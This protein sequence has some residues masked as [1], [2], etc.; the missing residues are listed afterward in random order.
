MEKDIYERCSRY[1]R[2]Y[3][4]V[5]FETTNVIRTCGSTLPLDIK[6]IN[7]HE[8][9]LICGEIQSVAQEIS[10]K[11]YKKLTAIQQELAIYLQRKSRA[12][13]YDCQRMVYMGALGDGGWKTCQDESYLLK[14]P[15]LVYSFG[16]GQDWTFENA[17]ILHGCQIHSFD[18]TIGLKSFVRFPSN[19]FHDV[20]IR[21]ENDPPVAK[22]IKLISKRLTADLRQDG[23]LSKMIDVDD[24]YGVIRKPGRFRIKKAWIR[25]SKSMGT[26]LG[27]GIFDSEK[28]KFNFKTASYK[29]RYVIEPIETNETR[30]MIYQ[31]G[32]SIWWKS[33]PFTD[34]TRMLGHGD[35]VIDILK[36]DIE[37]G[38]W[39]ILASLLN[40]P[41]PENSDLGS[42]F[43]GSKTHTTN[44]SS[45]FKLRNIRQ[46]LLEFHVWGVFSES[47]KALNRV[48]RVFD[49]LHN[50]G[51]R[52]FYS[53]GNVG[54]LYSIVS[55]G[56]YSFSFVNISMLNPT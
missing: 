35:T 2:I 30:R 29:D 40:I 14:S 11:N 6:P 51:M 21:Q 18:P 34:I 48:K 12:F 49:G 56:C 13:E 9:R 16:I 55:F 17:L 28:K 39:D 22:K 1:S 15:C 20:G 27:R 26:D 52:L 5:N 36:L 50:A 33:L 37:G 3:Q 23:H 54:D 24:Y 4:E 43:D 7:D 44:G 42:S 31:N 25:P 38:E 19:V 10:Y 47:I 32:D 45:N 8:M 41:V 46:M 53:C